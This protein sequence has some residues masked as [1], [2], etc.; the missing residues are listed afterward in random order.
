METHPT[1]SAT[2]VPRPDAG[3]RMSALRGLLL[4]GLVVLCGAGLVVDPFRPQNPR[5]FWTVAVAIFG[6]LCFGVCLLGGRGRSLREVLLDQALV[7]LGATALVQA[8]P[9]LIERQRL[10]PEAA[11]PVAV[12]WIAFA[13]FVSGVRFAWPLISV[14]LLL[15]AAVAG[16]VLLERIVLLVGGM[17]VVLVLAAFFIRPLL[18][19]FR[20]PRSPEP[21][22]GPVSGT[23]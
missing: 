15:V 19:A 13:V 16:A 18:R 21:P 12:L 23:A 20:G 22:S 5:A 14:A 11:G 6:A 2:P 7:W 8:L 4:L 9:W 17:A 10:S 1:E 3:G